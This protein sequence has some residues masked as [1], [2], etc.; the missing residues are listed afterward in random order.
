MGV[1]AVSFFP[2]KKLGAVDYSIIDKGWMINSRDPHEILNY[3][4]SRKV[5]GK[6]LERSRIIHKN[7]MNILNLII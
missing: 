2:G 6:K 4:K 3:I 1:P 5:F 7:F